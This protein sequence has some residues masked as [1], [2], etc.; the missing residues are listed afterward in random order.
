MANL[1]WLRPGLQLKRWVV[2]ICFGL[3]V[4]IIGA[5]IFGLRFF[6]ALE[7]GSS[8]LVTPYYF[9]SAVL[10]GG[11]GSAIFIGVYRLVRHIEKI[12]KRSHEN[13][14]LSEIALAQIEQGPKLVCVGGGTGLNRLL[15]GLREHSN[16]ITAVVSVADDGGSSGRL[17]NEFGMLPPGDIRNC[18]SAL[19]NAGDTMGALMQYRFAEGELAGHAFGN[20]LLMVLMK[21]TGDFGQAVR[22][23]N[24]ILNVRGQVLPVSLDYVTLVA[25]HPDGTK[26]T[27]QKNVARCGKPIAEL[28]LKPE[29]GAP[30]ADVL[31]AIAEADAIILG[32]GS[33]FTSVLPNLLL[34]AVAAAIADSPAKVI[35]VVNTANQPGETPNFAVNDYLSALKKHAPK[36]RIDVAIVNDYRPSPAK[37]E[38]L[39]GENRFLTEHVGRPADGVRLLFRDVVNRDRPEEHDVAKLAKAIMEELAGK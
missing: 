21:V 32:P 30:P 5:I 4:A 2:L 18:L 14:S 8:L 26:T 12:L 28:T 23:A 17:R 38:R 1:N 27:G 16:R 29:P 22:E 10:I 34:P 9:L 19:A 15:S 24:H 20:L 6:G 31:A 7:T 25:T 37:I 35:Y 3:F 36:L 11:G 33:L 39:R 13:R